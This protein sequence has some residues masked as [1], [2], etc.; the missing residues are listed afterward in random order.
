MRCHLCPWACLCLCL[1]LCHTPPQCIA[2]ACARGCA[3]LHLRALPVP[4][5]VGVPCSIL[6]ALPVPVLVPV[7]VPVPD[8]LDRPQAQALQAPPG[9]CA[10]CRGRAPPLPHSPLN[11]LPSHL[12]DRM[13]G[14]LQEVPSSDLAAC[15][16]LVASSYQHIPPETWTQARLFLFSPIKGLL[17][18]VQYLSPQATTS[19]CCGQCYKQTL[20]GPQHCLPLVARIVLSLCH[21]ALHEEASRLRVHSAILVEL[22]NRLTCRLGLRWRCHST[23]IQLQLCQAQPLH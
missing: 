7:P 4:V 23:P 11:P 22:S 17:P 5:P 1:C 12:D 21:R 2:C 9:A 16:Y 18:A 20:V 19:A 14:S 6:R 15:A 13:A 10:G 3:V 8:E